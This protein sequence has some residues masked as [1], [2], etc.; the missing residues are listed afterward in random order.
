MRSS[1]GIV[2]E[3]PPCH[4]SSPLFFT[5]TPRKMTTDNLVSAG[6]KIVCCYGMRYIG[7][8]NT[9]ALTGLWLPL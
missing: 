3:R 7:G 1:T 5:Q 6:R 4:F 8:F 2:Q 9:M